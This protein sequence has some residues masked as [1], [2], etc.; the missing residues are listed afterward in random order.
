ML[1]LRPVGTSTQAPS[2]QRRGALSVCSAR[3]PLPGTTIPIGVG[4]LILVLV[5][6]L[7]IFG[8]RRLPDVFKAIG[9]GVGKI[10]RAAGEQTADAS[11]DERATTP[12]GD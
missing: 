4:E 11:D 7:L 9:H 3:T 2:A 1:R 5:I 6:I 8:P 10:R 12:K